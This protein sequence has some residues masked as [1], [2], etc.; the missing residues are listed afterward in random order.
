MTTWAACL[1]VLAPSSRNKGI[2]RR[3][4][5]D[6]GVWGAMSGPTQSKKNL[7]GHVGAHP[8]EKKSGGPCRGPPNRK[9]IWGAM[10]G[11][12]QSIKRRRHHEGRIHR[13]G[14]HGTAHGA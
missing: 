8:I 13:H 10:S 9:K 12:T 14:H 2:D 5:A 6:W 7:G 11:P 4:P 1:L 3:P